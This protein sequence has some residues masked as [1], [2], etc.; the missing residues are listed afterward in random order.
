MHTFRRLATLLHKRQ[1]LKREEINEIMGWV[2]NSN[3]PVHYAAE[4]DS[5]LETAPANVFA[6]ELEQKIPFKKFQDIQFE[7]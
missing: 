3:M 2:P 4:Q 5:L 1:G 6:S 7:L